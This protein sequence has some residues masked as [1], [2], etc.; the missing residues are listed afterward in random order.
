MILWL[1][2]ET[3]GT[4]ESQDE[5]IE[6]GAILTRNDPGLTIIDTYAKV[7]KTTRAISDLTPVVY[8]MHVHNRLWHEIVNSATGYA[9]EDQEHIM[10]WLGEHNA[11]TQG[12]L[13]LGGS[14]VSHF[15]R[16]FI[17]RAWPALDKRLEYWS[18]DVGSMRRLARLGGAAF[19]PGKLRMSEPGI[20]HSAHRA[21]DDT[22]QALDEA[23]A[24][25]RAIEG[26][27]A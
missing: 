14:G 1:D 22:V 7:Y 12:R 17:K 19:G 4:D 15:D 25:V 10:A 3:T 9:E 27:S 24:F 11:F 26:L 8:D 5:I 21:L 16:R 20:D 6:L 2:L 23:R 13:A 18:Y